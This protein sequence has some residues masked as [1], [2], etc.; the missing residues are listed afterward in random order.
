LLGKMMLPL[1]KNCSFT[2]SVLC[3]FLSS[4]ILLFWEFI[5]LFFCQLWML[6]STDERTKKSIDT[7]HPLLSTVVGKL[8]SFSSFDSFG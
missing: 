6:F 2:V 3:A 8:S 4:F 1:Q 5:L 7:Q